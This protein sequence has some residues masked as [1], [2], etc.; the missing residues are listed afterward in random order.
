MPL[1]N[2]EK[3]LYFFFGNRLRAKFSTPE[4]LI[5]IIFPK[6][7]T[8]L[9]KNYNNNNNNNNNNSNNREKIIIIWQRK[10]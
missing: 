3:V 5:S 8:N 1:W 2:G 6:K 4:I 10:I 9:I 7:H